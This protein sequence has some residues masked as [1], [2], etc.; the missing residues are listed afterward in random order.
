MRS[1]TSAATRVEAT[2]DPVVDALADRWG[3][4]PGVKNAVS[5]AKGRLS[6]RT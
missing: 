3:I 4:S 6:Q 1:R 5:G 2:D